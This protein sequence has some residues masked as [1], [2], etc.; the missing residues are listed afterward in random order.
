MVNVILSFWH[1][2]HGGATPYFLIATGI[3]WSNG[4]YFGN[5]IFAELK[6][7][8]L[9]YYQNPKV[10]FELSDKLGGTD[11]WNYKSNDGCSQLTV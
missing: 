1:T 8:F 7:T 10:K 5:A 9:E 11:M 4:M 6:N 2:T 3:H